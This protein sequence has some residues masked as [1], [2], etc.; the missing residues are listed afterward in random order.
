MFF[1][2]EGRKGQSMAE[3][4]IFGS[5]VLFIFGMLLSYLQR[6]NDQQYV[7]MEN[8]R[9]TLTIANLGGLTVDDAVNGGA[10]AS[11]TSM[12]TRR[13]VDL[14][15]NYQKR[16]P[17]TMS[18]SAQVF[19]AVPAVGSE[20]ES[21]SYYKVNEDYS[22]DFAQLEDPNPDDDEDPNAVEN[23]NTSSNTAFSEIMDKQESQAA[24]ANTRTSALK[25]TISTNLINKAGDSLWSV[26]QNLYRDNSGQYKYKEG[27]PSEF[28]IRSKTWETNF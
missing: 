4:A 23:V 1:G 8:F 5:I 16:S 13:H 6:M 11:L 10:A 17:Q 18:S 7:Q 12:E 28:I 27:V 20:P 15:G 3:L 25:D 22:P 26:T 9:T 21:R 19:W 14:S 24:I 2:R